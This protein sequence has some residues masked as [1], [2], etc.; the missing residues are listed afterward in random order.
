MKR[1]LVLLMALSLLTVLAGCFC[2]HQW[3]D[4]TC[5]APMTC[6]NC[7]KTEG[8]PLGHTWAA[9]TCD[10]PKT[11]E[12]CQKTEGEP[13]GHTWLD[14]TC[15]TAKKCSLCHTLEGQPLDHDWEDATT[16]APKTCKNCQLTEG[17]K[18]DTDPRFTTAATKHLY[19]KWYAD[20]AI[21]GEA[22]ELEDYI[23]ELSVTMF[24]EFCN[25]GTMLV[26]MELHD[27]LQFMEDM[28]TIMMD[29]MYDSLKEQGISKS[30]AD[31]VILQEYGMTM[32]EYVD[33]YLATL[34]IASL[35]EEYSYQMVYYVTDG[36]I[37]NAED[38]NSEFEFSE[39]SLEDGILII[40]EM[41]I[42]E[43]SEPLQWKL[44]EE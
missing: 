12:V 10:A 5:E 32:E 27:Q 26:S 30:Q 42:D 28:K 22:M 41:S 29:I 19:G 24:M 11:C 20:V 21:P 16:E 35:L 25:D 39:Y 44:V 1:I 9:A 4:A 36:G 14:A 6:A 2:N 13:K 33:A 31:A 15:T 40:N 7:E 38:W 8:A 3:Q 23:D 18:I 37:Y 34:D 17:T 43:D